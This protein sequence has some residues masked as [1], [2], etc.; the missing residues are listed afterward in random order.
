[1]ENEAVMPRKSPRPTPSKAAP[2][3]AY[4]DGVSLELRL[5]FGHGIRAGRQKAGLT[6]TEVAARTGIQQ[7]YISDLEIGKQN[8]TLSTMVTL[9][10]CIGEDVS[11]LLKLPSDK[12]KKSQ[13]GKVG[14]QAS[15]SSSVT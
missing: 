13:A 14:C 6:Q 8:P 9:A 12:P 10:L 5:A 11:S 1:L 2:G 7:T 4:A 3:A 15:C